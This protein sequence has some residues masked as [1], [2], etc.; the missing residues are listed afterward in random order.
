MNEHEPNVICAGHINWDVTMHVDRLPE[1]DGEVQIRKLIQSG[2]GSAANVAVGLSGLEADATVFGSVGG[3]DSGAFALRE[4][5]RSG[6][7]CGHV[8]V[9]K[10]ETTAVKYLVVDDCGEVMVFASDGANEAFSAGDLPPRVVATADHLHLTSQRPETAVELAALVRDVGG[11]VSFDPGRRIGQRAFKRAFPYV[12]V[13]FCNRREAERSADDYRE[14][15]PD[16]GL[17]VIKRGGDGAS[18]SGPDG[19]VSHSGYEIDAVDTTGA[20]DAFAAG[21]LAAWLGSRAFRRR[22]RRDRGPSDSEGFPDDVDD[23]PL[24]EVLAVANACGALTAM[25]ATA[26]TELAWD[27]IASLVENAN[28]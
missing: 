20:G 19:T 8:L 17:L 2:G 6:V 27:R 21:F 11:T 18:V 15:G 23:P 16:D 1:P 24:E 9:A 10:S 7:E 13:L 26:R 14:H 4:L 5:D 25:E 3:D 22:F 28:R 12:D